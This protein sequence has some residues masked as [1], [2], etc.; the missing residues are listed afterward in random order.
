MLTSRFNQSSLLKGLEPIEWGTYA[1]FNTFI[2]FICITQVKKNS[3]QITMSH[4]LF[5]L[6]GLFTTIMAQ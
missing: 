3:S 2:E 6:L 4:G 5:L 1:I